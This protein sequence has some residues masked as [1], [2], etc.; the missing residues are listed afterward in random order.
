[1]Y[2]TLLDTWHERL[3][4]CM[5]VTLGKLPAG[6]LC[7]WGARGMYYVYIPHRSVKY[8][9]VDRRARY[10]KHSEYYCH[11]CTNYTLTRHGP[12]R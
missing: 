1:M 3:L 6:G 10:S 4:Y 8:E 9:S 11:D 12:T 7:E 2:N 5:G